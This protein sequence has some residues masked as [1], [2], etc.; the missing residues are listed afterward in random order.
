MASLERETLPIV[1]RL[2]PGNDRPSRV[3]GVKQSISMII[4]GSN[5]SQ[6]SIKMVIIVQFV[7]RFLTPSL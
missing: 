6:D 3:T 2:Y 1:Q 4:N 7:N 5:S